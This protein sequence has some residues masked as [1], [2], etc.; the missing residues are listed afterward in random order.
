MKNALILSIIIPVYNLE[1]YIERCLRSILNAELSSFEIICINDGSQDDSYNL[2]LNIAKQNDNIRVITGDNKGV[3]SA[4]NTGI[5]AAKGD[6][7]WFIDGDDYL[8]AKRVNETLLALKSHPDIHCIN[9]DYVNETN[10]H[11]SKNTN[12]KGGGIYNIENFIQHIYNNKGMPWAFIL[13]RELIT[14]NNV[15]FDERMRYYED[16]QFIYK[17]LSFAKLVTS[18][19]VVVYHYIIRPT[20]AL[21]IA[22]FQDRLN[23]A[24]IIYSDLIEFSK[25]KQNYF[26]TFIS[27]RASHTICWAIRN[28][29]TKTAFKH[30]SFLKREKILPLAIV[31]PLKIKIQVILLNFNFTLFRFFSKVNNIRE[32][33]G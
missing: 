6:Y 3:S 30:Y 13:K 20:S 18:N 26:K 15:L 9:F 10:L 27:K 33:V 5:S 2:L 23:D 11:I 28:S 24:I 1:N 12:F 31:G 16:E 22:D 25:D 4:R 29:E 21:R 19:S 17:L 8:E 14:D 32:K 7:I